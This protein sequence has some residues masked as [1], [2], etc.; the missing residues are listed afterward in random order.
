MILYN[1]TFCLDVNAVDEWRTWM[2]VYFLPLIRRSGYFED[3]KI[4]KLIQED[5]TG[6]IN[7]CCQLSANTLND[8]Q[9]FVIEYESAIGENIKSTFGERCLPFS[10][11]LEITEE[12]EM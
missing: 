5:Q 11:M 9:L 1:T 10:S 8:Y 12:G 7:Y 2:S 6:T 4:L 3:Y